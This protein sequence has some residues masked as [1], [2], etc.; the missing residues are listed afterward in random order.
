MIE[1]AWLAWR[2]DAN[3]D[4]E[5][6]EPGFPRLDGVQRASL[7]LVPHGKRVRKVE[8]EPTLGRDVTAVRR[9]VRSCFVHG[10]V[11]LHESAPPD[12]QSDE[13][14]YDRGISET[15]G[16]IPS[17]VARG[18]QGEFPPATLA[19]VGRRALATN[20]ST[21]WSTSRVA[22]GVTGLRELL[23]PCDMSRRVALRSAPD[24]LYTQVVAGSSPAPPILARLVKPIRLSYGGQ[25][26]RKCRECST[27]AAPTQPAEARLRALTCGRGEAL[28]VLCPEV[29]RG[30]VGSHRRDVALHEVPRTANLD[31]A[32]RWNRLEHEEDAPGV[33]RQVAELD[34]AFRRSRP[35]TILRP[36]ETKPGKRSRCRLCDRSSEQPATEPRAAS[37]R[38]RATLPS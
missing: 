35:R 15:G 31:A 32:E 1:G 12:E 29:A 23:C 30:D 22:W 5:V 24:T 33:A 37:E 11:V 26:C 36:S 16:T 18:G 8:Y 28:A 2:N 10:H 17:E 25:V 38:L 19:V 27:R 21:S 13:G 20:W 9:L 7:L 6:S 14:A 3:V 34:V 4:A